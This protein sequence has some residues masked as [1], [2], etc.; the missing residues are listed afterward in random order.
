MHPC[1]SPLGQG[2]MVADGTVFSS[3]QGSSKKNTSRLFRTACINLT[4]ACGGRNPLC[5]EL[6]AKTQGKGVLLA[7]P[8]VEQFI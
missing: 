3:V 1:V 5:P 8:V 7:V 6:R 4:E 2:C